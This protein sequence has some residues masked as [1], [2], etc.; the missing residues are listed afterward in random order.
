METLSAVEAKLP[1]EQ[2]MRTHRSY[3]VN[4]GRVLQIAPWASRHL[5]SEDPRGR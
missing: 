5:Q 4:V 3:V 1:A 2:F